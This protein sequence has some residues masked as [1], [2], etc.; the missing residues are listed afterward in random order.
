MNPVILLYLWFHVPESHD[1]VME[2]F[3]L[4]SL[5]IVHVHVQHLLAM[6]FT[7]ITPPHIDT[8]STKHYTMMKQISHFKLAP[9]LFA[10]SAHLRMGSYRRF[11]ITQVRAGWSIMLDYIY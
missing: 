5:N 4:G 10:A 9:S 3:K 1:C 7:S 2:S 11:H 6:P 8:P